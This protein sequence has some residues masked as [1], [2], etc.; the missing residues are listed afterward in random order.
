MTQQAALPPKPILRISGTHKAAHTGEH[1]T[2]FDLSF[3]LL[4]LLDLESTPTGDPISRLRLKTPP[5]PPSSPAGR[6]FKSSSSAS[7]AQSPLNLWARQFTLHDK[8]ENRSFTLTRTILDYESITKLLEGHI[9]TLLANLKYR[10]KLEVSFPIEHQSITVHRPPG[11]WLVSMLRLYPVKKYEV[12]EAVWDVG[13]SDVAGD[14]SGAGE[15]GTKAAERWWREWE[16]VVRNG[17]LR[18][19]KGLMGVENWI[20]WKMGGSAEE[21]RV[22]WGADWASDWGQ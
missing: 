18:K 5:N 8:S 1:T 3:S 14:G 11:N 2:D 22:E 19:E 6:L 10:G 13:S 9:R 20:A 15:E 16:G 4:S 12:A 7:G 21:K 17:V